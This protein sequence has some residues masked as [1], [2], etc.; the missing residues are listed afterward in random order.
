MLRYLKAQARL[1]GDAN[2]AAVKLEPWVVHDLRRTVRTKLAELEVNDSVAEMIIG[3]GRRG[4]QRVYDQSAREPA[5]RVAAERW[6]AELRRIVA[7]QRRDDGVV[8]PL[9]GQGA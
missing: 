2:W 9:R 1:R 3:H 7:N 5:I 8:V 4:L 6:A